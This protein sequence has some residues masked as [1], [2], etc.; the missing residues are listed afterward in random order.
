M[1]ALTKARLYL[2]VAILLAVFWFVW[3]ASL[4]EASD[5]I[6]QS[7]D[8]N[9]QTAGTVDT[10]STALGFGRSSFDVDIAQCRESHSWDTIIVGKQTVKLNKWCV[11]LWYDS[12]GLH[13]MAAVMRCDINEISKH[14]PHA[15]GCIVANKLGG[16]V[17]M[18][19]A[20]VISHIEEED[21]HEQELEEQ[22]ILLIDMQ[23]QIYAL[24]QERQEPPQ[25][26]RETR[27]EQKPLLTL[28]QI[29]SLRIEK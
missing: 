7:N 14:F 24:E 8:M 16:F 28:D 3:G 20:E 6:T 15:E 18:P 10:G 13:H 21:E 25:I 19:T 17:S 27:V 22:Q 2:V 1:T 29:E 12:Q 23:E 9:N 4:A 11:A 26:I 5:R